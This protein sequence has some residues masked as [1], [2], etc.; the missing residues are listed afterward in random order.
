MIILSNF[1]KIFVN[2]VVVMKLHKILF[3]LII[4]F[5]G[6]T[7][8]AKGQYSVKLRD[9]KEVISNNNELNNFG[10]SYNLEELAE[11]AS[12]TLKYSTVFPTYSDVVKVTAKPKSNF[13]YTSTGTEFP[14][15]ISEF[16]RKQILVSKTENGKISVT[17]KP[18][19]EADKKTYFS[20]RLLPAGFGSEGRLRNAFV[21]TIN[22][23][24][25]ELAV[26]AK[27]KIN[28][29]KYNGKLYYSVGVKGVF[30]TDKSSFSS[31]T[32]YECGSWLM[33]IKI[34]NLNTDSLGYQNFHN[35][36]VQIFNPSRLTAVNPLYDRPNLDFN[37]DGLQEPTLTGVLWAAAMKKI[38]W[39]SSEVTNA[40][41]AAGFPDLYLNMHLESIKEY[42]KIEKN[43]ITL[44]SKAE[45]YYNDLLA[46]NNAGF[47]PEYIM[48]QYENVMIVPSNIQLNFDAYH[49]W[50]KDKDIQVN[51]R[52]KLYNISYRNLPY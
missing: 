24:S 7:Q 52:K 23:F 46:I 11:T 37:K 22:V 12:V 38:N 6:T 14:Y 21:E 29:V 25:K 3:F 18:I 43:K 50:K 9:K 32:L 30:K 26:T 44:N 17:Y 13:L 19:L 28:P 41:R 33:E 15:Q 34:V 45:R 20:I 1:A 31:L 36:L 8:F 2:D 42:L 5:L 10:S 4:L 48:E 35:E 40:E 39:A 47:L 27:P 16:V 51:I 49:Q